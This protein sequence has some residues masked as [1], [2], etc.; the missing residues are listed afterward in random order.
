MH[1]LGV[2]V[3]VWPWIEE[4]GPDEKDYSSTILRNFDAICCNNPILM[5]EA[6]QARFPVKMRRDVYTLEER[7]SKVYI[8]LEKL[9]DNPDLKLP[10][11]I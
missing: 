9:Q 5:R 1:S 8:I 10:P 6:I 7:I 11:M 3:G 2:V 4:Y